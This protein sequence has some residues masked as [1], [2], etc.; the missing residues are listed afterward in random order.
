MVT[1]Y[2]SNNRSILVFLQCID[3]C[4]SLVIING[5]FNIIGCYKR[6]II[7]NE[8]LFSAQLNKNGGDINVNNASNGK[9]IQVDAGDISYHIMQNLPSNH[10]FL[11]Y[12]TTLVH[13]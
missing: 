9:K 2:A 4:I 7:N 1:L 5:G 13:K 3:S 10:E 11:D 12:I 8:S 6:V